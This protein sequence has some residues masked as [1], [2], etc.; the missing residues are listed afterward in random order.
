[1]VGDLHGLNTLKHQPGETRRNGRNLG[2]SARRTGGSIRDTRIRVP[3]QISF[4][5]AI[6]K[7]ASLYLTHDWEGEVKGVKAFGDNH[8]PVGTGVL[9]ISHHGRA[10]GC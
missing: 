2:N 6:P 7:L 8:P 3:S 10:W 5:I 1:L 4:E 9:G